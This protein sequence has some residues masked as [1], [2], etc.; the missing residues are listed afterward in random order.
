MFLHNYSLFFKFFT[1]I[2]VGDKIFQIWFQIEFLDCSII[3]FKFISNKV[4]K[5][6]CHHII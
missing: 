3:N 4:L 6:K 1:R 5:I 2:K